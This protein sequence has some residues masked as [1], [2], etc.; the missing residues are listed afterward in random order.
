MTMESSPTSPFEYGNDKEGKEKRRKKATLRIPLPASEIHA[1][2]QP[3]KRE[4]ILPLFGAKEEFG[5]KEDKRDVTEIAGTHE[6]LSDDNATVPPHKD[7]TDIHNTL[8]SGFKPAEITMPSPEQQ[9]A[10]PTVGRDNQGRENRVMPGDNAWAPQH[11]AWG[12]EHT[13]HLQAPVPI[14]RMPDS[15]PLQAETNEEAIAA[16][17]SVSGMAAEIAATE[18]DPELPWDLP[19]SPV[20]IPS[21]ETPAAVFAADEPNEQPAL[22]RP[23]P[24]YREPMFPYGS[25]GQPQPVRP[26]LVETVTPVVPP[27]EQRLHDTAEQKVVHSEVADMVVDRH[28]GALAEGEGI[29]EF[30]REFHAE[31]RAEAEPP[32]PLVA[33]LAA[34]QAAARTSADVTDAYRQEHGQ[35]ISHG[36]NASLPSGQIG[37]AHELPPGNT[38]VDYGHRLE[39]PRNPIIAAAS[40]PLLWV[41]VAVLIAAFLAAAFM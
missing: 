7:F 5:T 12:E 19:P 8:W 25:G 23:E 36:Y 1:T 30:G 26:T 28:T 3:K 24:A 17:P 11:T 6:E 10:Q 4:R 21:V 13:V 22:Y 31:Q 27:V 32:D 40:K 14:E 39:K 35:T 16:A 2:E 34:A 29:N 41:G 33:A 15:P 20:P 18:P 37:P 9:P 38:P